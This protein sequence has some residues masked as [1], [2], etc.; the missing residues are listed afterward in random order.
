MTA[1]IFLLAT[2]QLWLMWRIHRK[3]I[4]QKGTV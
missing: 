1:L 2:G 3:G 4:Q